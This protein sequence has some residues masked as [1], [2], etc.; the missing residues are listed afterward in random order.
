MNKTT[1]TSTTG[2]AE[3]DASLN[4]DETYDE[5]PEVKAMLSRLSGGQ[6]QR[7]AIA[8]ALVRNQAIL[9]LDSL[10]SRGSVEIVW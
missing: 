5:L 6:R 7:V 4:L 8:R 1:R 10:R 2:D 3:K 9:L